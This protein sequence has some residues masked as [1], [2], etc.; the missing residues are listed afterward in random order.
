[1]CLCY[2]RV[3]LKTAEIEKFASVS[4]C[5]QARR[6]GTGSCQLLCGRGPTTTHVLHAQQ[7]MPGWAWVHLGLSPTTRMRPA[8]P[9]PWLLPPAQGVNKHT[10]SITATA[11]KVGEKLSGLATSTAAKY[12]LTPALT[13][14]RKKS[15]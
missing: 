8:P 2:G 14:G 12:E 15:Q 13:P 6:D 1:M 5:N 10:K 3:T 9:S 4:A 7:R 11:S